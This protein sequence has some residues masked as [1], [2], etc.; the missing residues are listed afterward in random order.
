MA[1]TIVNLSALQPFT[2]LLSTEKERLKYSWKADL[3]CSAAQ[4]AATLYFAFRATGK[5]I[6]EAERL[7]G[8]LA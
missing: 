3:G 7:S 6:S 4:F 2:S 8:N 5:K 1:F